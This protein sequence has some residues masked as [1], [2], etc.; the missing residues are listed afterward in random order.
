MSAPPLPVGVDG[1]LVKNPDG[2][3]TYAIS[4]MDA[5]SLAGVTA[6]K[7]ERWIQSGTV[8]FC[9]RPISGERLVLVDSLWAALPPELKE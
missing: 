2:S 8:E 5:A 7:I 6:W 9:R 3:E 4:V 1:F